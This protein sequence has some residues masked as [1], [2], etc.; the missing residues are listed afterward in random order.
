MCSS[1]RCAISCLSIGGVLCLPAQISELRRLS[2][3]SKASLSIVFTNLLVLAR[4]KAFRCQFSSPE[5]LFSIL[6]G[7]WFLD[8]VEISF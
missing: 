3:V 7:V 8:A 4:Y 5:V 6:S 2:C 1:T